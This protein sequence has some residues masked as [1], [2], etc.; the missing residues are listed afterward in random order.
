MDAARRAEFTAILRTRDPRLSLVTGADSRDP[1]RAAHWIVY[2]LSGSEPVKLATLESLD[3]D[4]MGHRPPGRW[5]VDAL[6]RVNWRDK[7]L[8]VREGL[9]KKARLEEALD[10]AHQERVRYTSSSRSPF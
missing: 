1:A 8:R 4:L 7:I 2:H 5:I 3:C 10:A 6:Q 9:L